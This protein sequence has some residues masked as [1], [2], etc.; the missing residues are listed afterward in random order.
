MIRGLWEVDGHGHLQ[1]LW[2]DPAKLDQGVRMRP[3]G[4]DFGEIA[5]QLGISERALQNGLDPSDKVDEGALGRPWRDPDIERNIRL[6]KAQRCNGGT[7]DAST[8]PG[9]HH[10]RQ[11]GA[12]LN[13]TAASRM[14]ANSCATPD[15][16][17]LTF[18]LCSSRPTDETAG[19]RTLVRQS[20]SQPLT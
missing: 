5:R 9:E 8:P 18:E 7:R 12:D 17:H 20:D 13:K 15:K 1:H 4:T 11:R 6:L 16:Q 10:N 2:R 14:D 3:T 19:P